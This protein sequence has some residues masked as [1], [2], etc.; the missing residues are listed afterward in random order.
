MKNI[1]SIEI[2]FFI[3]SLILFG[4][5]LS[6]PDVIPSRYFSIRTKYNYFIFN[7]SDFLYDEDIY[8]TIKSK[9]KCSYS[10]DY[11]FYDNLEEISVPNFDDKFKARP[12][13]VEKNEIL[14]VKQSLSLYFNILK[15]KDILFRRKGNLLYIEFNCVD[16]V[17]IINTKNKKENSL[18]IALYYFSFG[19]FFIMCF[20]I[21]KAIIYSLIVITKKTYVIKKNWNKNNNLENINNNIFFQHNQNGMNF[22]IERIVYVRQEQNMRNANNINSNDR[23]IYIKSN[24]DNNNQNYPSFDDNLNNNCV[25]NINESNIPV[26][27]Q[28]KSIESSESLNVTYTND[29]NFYTPQNN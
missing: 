18:S 5:V 28:N 19:L 20:I 21:I 24:N 29:K 26:N 11:F 10:L 23:S 7:V 16:E 1:P 3:L 6:S 4:K 25:R 22:P 8:L 12:Y 15:R 13:L 27:Y 14:G 2:S 9:S 17:E